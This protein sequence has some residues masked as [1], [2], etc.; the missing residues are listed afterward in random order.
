[1]IKSACDVPHPRGNGR[2]TA[3][4]IADAYNCVVTWK[5]E[6]TKRG[7]HVAN[8]SPGSHAELQVSGNASN[9]E[10]FGNAAGQQIT[11][12]DRK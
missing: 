10:I 8:N 2:M 1:M 3:E 9:K 7:W 4:E 6:N 5:T 11:K 12:N